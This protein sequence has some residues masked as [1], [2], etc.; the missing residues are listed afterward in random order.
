MDKLSFSSDHVNY[1]LLRYLQESGFKHSSFVFYNESNQ[2]N[3]VDLDPSAVPPGA[4]IH[5]LQKG[6]QF[7]ELEA[8][9]TQDGNNMDGEFSFLESKDL[10]TKSIEELR[11]TVR[12]QRDSTRREKDEKDENVPTAMEEDKPE[13]EVS[14][15]QV[16]TL[17]GHS[18]EVYVCAWSPTDCLLASGSGDGTA[19]LWPNAGKAQADSG[20]AC[21]TPIVLMHADGQAP[22]ADGNKDVTTLDWSPDGQQLATGSY[23]GLVRVWSKEGTLVKTLTSH[24]NPVFAL[25][26]NK[27]GSLVLTG[28]VD[29]TAVVWDPKFPE[30]KQR[31]N[32][33][34]GAILDVDW[35]NNVA[36]ATCSGDK[37][38]HVCKLGEDEPVKTF[39]GHQKEVNTVWWGVRKLLASGSDD[40]TARIWSLNQDDAVHVLKGHKK[41]VYQVR[42]SP[43]TNQAPPPSVA[44]ASF[45]MTVK[46]WDVESGRNV[47]TLCQHTSPVYSVAFSPDGQYLASGSFDEKVCIWSVRDGSLVRSFSAEGGVFDLCWNKSGDKIAASCNNADVYILDFRL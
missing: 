45:D 14:P 5:I 28:S 27:K 24:S 6:F 43:V 30:P 9:L 35:R 34:S 19:R 16:T 10:I 20:Q 18:A 15:G 12:E 33:H 47:Y 13:M 21:E 29:H 26:W 8:N 17:K 3:R 41:E 39:R 2:A 46:L 22:K 7:I 1:L 31:F 42:W 32:F 38:I 4:L 37:L 11:E 36:F 25:K 23:C 40:K 44:T